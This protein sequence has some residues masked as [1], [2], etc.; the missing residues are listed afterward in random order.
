[1]SSVENTVT[2]KQLE[3]LKAGVDLYKKLSSKQGVL[4]HIAHARKENHAEDY[5]SERLLSISASRVK[6][7]VKGIRKV[8]DTFRD[9][10]LGREE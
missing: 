1:M 8:V 3:R 10:S 4:Y 6:N 7:D 9:R 2:P 5:D